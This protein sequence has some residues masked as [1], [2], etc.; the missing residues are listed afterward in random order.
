MSTPTLPD[1][2][3]DLESTVYR[4]GHRLDGIEAQTETFAGDMRRVRGQLDDLSAQVREQGLSIREIRAD[5][6]QLRAGQD[7]LRADVASMI[8]R[9]GS[10]ERGMT[11]LLTHFDISVPP[12][13]DEG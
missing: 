11:A 7:D 3:R 9:I 8:T 1:R 4:T 2:V 13:G 5:V 10:L 6:H 12:A